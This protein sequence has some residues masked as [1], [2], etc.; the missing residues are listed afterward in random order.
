M[1][2]L[3]P[4]PKGHAFFAL[5]LDIDGCLRF[6]AAVPA[7]P[8]RPKVKLKAKVQPMRR[9]R[10]ASNLFL[11][12]LPARDASPKGLYAIGCALVAHIVKLE[13]E[14]HARMAAPVRFDDDLELIENAVNFIVPSRTEVL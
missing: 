7:T 12:C 9:T 5:E 3:P 10:A 8:S 13:Q 11:Y 14:R 6:L 2:A 4:V 1:S